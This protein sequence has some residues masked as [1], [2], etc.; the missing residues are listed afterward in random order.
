MA[1]HGA[2]KFDPRKMT[3][4]SILYII[5]LDKNIIIYSQGEIRARERTRTR[6]GAR[7]E[8]CQKKIASERKIFDLWLCQSNIN[9]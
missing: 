3:L 5:I 4:S 6:E 1:N 8:A 2:A 9:D 7:L